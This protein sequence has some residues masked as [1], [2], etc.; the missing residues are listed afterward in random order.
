MSGDL[1]SA[2]LRF[3]IKDIAEAKKRI[4]RGRLAAL[5]QA[6][7]IVARKTKLKMSGPRPRYLGVISNRL[8]SSWA[9]VAIGQR[10]AVG[11][12]VV[13]AR[14]HQE[15]GMIFAHK[16]IT[17]KITRGPNKGAEYTTLRPWLRFKTREGKWVITDRVRIPRREGVY[18]ALDESVPEILDHLQKVITGPLF[19]A[20][21]RY[22]LGR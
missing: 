16:G 13:Y 5:K 22:E 18:E 19:I 10:V 3:L 20:G 14:I 17:M 2:P 8:R 15:G 12:N 9:V 4:E 1:F 21:K 11:T 6:G 7:Y